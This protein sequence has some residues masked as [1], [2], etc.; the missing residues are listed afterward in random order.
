MNI[1]NSHTQIHA[2]PKIYTATKKDHL[3]FLFEVIDLLLGWT[4]MLSASNASSTQGAL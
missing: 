4:H 1:T 2:I 3:S